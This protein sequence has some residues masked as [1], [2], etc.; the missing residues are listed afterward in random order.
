[1]ARETRE[2]HE[3]G[4]IVRVFRVLRGKINSPARRRRSQ[5]EIAPRGAAA[6]R[7]AMFDAR[8]LFAALL[9]SATLA[10]AQVKLGNE[11]LAE[12][13]FKELRGKRVGLITNP[14][15][16]NSQVQST[17]DVLR[18]APDVKLVA[19]F[20]PEHGLNADVPAGT[21]YPNSTD[22]RT[23]LPG[24]SLSGPGPT[25]RPTRAMLQR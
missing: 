24:Y 2:R 7:S 25:R 1:M 6:L 20:A 9:L 3:T 11:T 18:R 16:V 23:R 15:G 8:R 12:G 17:I 21:E 13:G 10:H 14:S 5:D 22:A 19:L 4:E